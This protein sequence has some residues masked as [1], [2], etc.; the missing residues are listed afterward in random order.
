MGGTRSVLEMAQH[1]ADEGNDSDA[2]ALVRF[3]LGTD[4]DSAPAHV[5]LA[6][7]RAARGEVE[8]AVDTLVR[9]AQRIASTVPADEDPTGLYTMFAAA[10]ELAPARLDLH[11]DLAEVQARHGDV[12]GAQARLV[13]LSAIYIDAGRP[14]DARDVLAVASR[15]DPQSSVA[16]VIETEIPI[17]ESVPILLEEVEEDDVPQPAPAPKRQPRALTV[18]TP[19]LLRDA[20]GSV[21]PN[22][23]A[24]PP[25]TLGRR[26]RR[27]ATQTIC[28]PTL[29]R[30]S[31]GH[32][33]PNQPA[34]PEPPTG[35]R[36][37]RTRRP[38]RPRVH[39]DADA[40]LAARLRKLG[41]ATR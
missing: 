41:A 9:T 26:K 6:R 10:L 30:D 33:L 31:E 17:E 7:L 11:V 24:V 13:Q 15:W 21:L 12:P 32:L 36:A 8:L 28:T 20:A 40:P 5:R 4:P 23:A 35:R 14:E 38:R 3:A 19:T 25:P 34:V 37:R 1:F 16:G 29:L 18:C 22:Q 27:P 2:E 39:I